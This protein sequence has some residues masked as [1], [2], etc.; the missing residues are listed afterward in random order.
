[1]GDMEMATH[2]TKSMGLATIPISVFYGDKQD[3]QL[4]RVCFAKGEETLEK[5]A[6]ILCKI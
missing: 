1:M 3:D 6:K 5:A 2:L 4:L